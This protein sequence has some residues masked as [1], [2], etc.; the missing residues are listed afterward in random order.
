ME[1]QIRVQQVPEQLCVSL[2]RYVWGLR[3]ERLSM[4]QG[5]FIWLVLPHTVPKQWTSEF[6]LALY[7]PRL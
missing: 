1:L 4:S 2:V 5:N 6:R 3:T 7:P